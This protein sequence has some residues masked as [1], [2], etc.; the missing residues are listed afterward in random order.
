MYMYVCR[1]DALYRAE[2]EELL[3]KGS[4]AK[5]QFSEIYETPKGGCEI[6]IESTRN[7]YLGVRSSSFDCEKKNVQPS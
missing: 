5:Y 4:H 7:T 2:L 3:S 1:T 6:R